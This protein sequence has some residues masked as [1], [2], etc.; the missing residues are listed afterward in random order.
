[1]ALAPKAAKFVTQTLLPLFIACQ[2]RPKPVRL[3]RINYSV[4][5]CYLVSRL[6][7]SF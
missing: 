1:M 5:L 2:C 6:L 7:L 4:P 3:E